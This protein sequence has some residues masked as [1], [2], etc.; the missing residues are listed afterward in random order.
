MR[1]RFIGHSLRRM[2]LGGLL[3][4]VMASCQGGAGEPEDR[5]SGYAE[6]ESAEL[7]YPDLQAVPAPAPRP[8]SRLDRQ[9]LV[10]LLGDRVPAAAGDPCTNLGGICAPQSFAPTTSCGGFTDTCDSKG[11]QN[12]VFVDF[13]CQAVN[14]NAICTAI[15][16]QAVVTVECTR[17]T[18]G[19][20]C[21]ARTCDAPFCLGYSSTCAEQTTQVRNCLSAGV[22][23]N[24]MC[25][26]R[27]ATQEAV[28][29][30]QRNT[31][32]DRGCGARCNPGF[33]GECSNGACGC[34]CRNC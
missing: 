34:T 21:A 4:A 28:G 3:V 16:Q 19:L 30:C 6:A 15:A 33:V 8:G 5:G 23:S 29:T 18:N 25:T 9:Q 7:A 27:T 1:R 26:G 11:S 20:S 24:D 2:F 17:A 14:G 31:D 13:T 12:G 22:C 10:Q 32:G